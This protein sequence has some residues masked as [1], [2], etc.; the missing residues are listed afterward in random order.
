MLFGNV[1]YLTSFRRL[2]NNSSH[3]RGTNFVNEDNIGFV[4]CVIPIH[5]HIKFWGK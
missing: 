3:Y 5:K 4:L 2:Q 1:R